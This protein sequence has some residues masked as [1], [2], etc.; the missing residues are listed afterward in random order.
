[1]NRPVWPSV[2]RRYSRYATLHRAPR[3]D[4]IT[5][6][7]AVFTDSRRAFLAE[8]NPVFPKVIDFRP[9]TPGKNLVFGGYPEGP[10]C[11]PDYS[12]VP[13]SASEQ[14]LKPE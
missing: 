12:G 11:L 6:I 9:D 2:T 8:K 10:G 3:A 7:L 1:M 4:D 13:A 14:C 5:L